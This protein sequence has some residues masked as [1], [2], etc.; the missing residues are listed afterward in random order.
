MR[1]DE[2]GGGR[3][4]PDGGLLQLLLGR[5]RS[6]WTRVRRFAAALF[7]RAR[8]ER[9]MTAEMAHHLELEIEDRVRRGMEPTEARR[10]AL[11]D[12]GGVERW[13]EEGRAARGVGGWDVL[14]QDLR[15]AWRA[16][17][18]SPGF[19]A[20]S[21]LTL[22]LGIGA[23]TAV[24]SVVDGLLL[25]PL[26]YHEPDR[27]VRLLDYRE[28][29]SG[30]GTIS[31]PNFYDWL[32][33]ST[34]FEAGALYDEYSPTLRLEGEAMKLEAAS[35]GAAYFDVLGVRPAAGRLFVAEDDEP[36]SR[37][38]VLSW[39]LWQELFGGS[40]DA[41]GRTLD[42][43][44]FPYTV[45]GVAQPME[46]PRLSYSSTTG[47]RLWRSTP[48]YFPT[49]GRGGRS[50]TAIAR[51]KPGVSVSEAQAELSAIY[52]RLA[53]EYPEANAGHIVRVA[54][55][56]DDLVGE[57]RPVL[58]M[59]LGA[60]GLVLLIA[61]ANVANLLL[62][63]AAGRSREIALRSALGASRGRIVRQLLVESLLLS[64]AGAVAGIGIAV[65]ATG[66]VLRLAAGHLPRVSG[67]GLDP[68]V[69]SFALAA[70]VFATLVF[71]LIPALQT[72]RPE[73]AE[74]LKEGGRGSAGS[75]R[76]GR[77]RTTVVAAEV[78]LAVVVMLGA[79]LLGRSLLR[80]HAVDPGVAADRTLVMRVDPPFDP[81][82]PNTAE[83][84]AA[85]MA[86]ND[87]LHERL[88]RVPGVEAVGITDLLPMSGNFNGNGFR[89][90]GRPE[91]EPGQLPSAE[92]RAIDPHYFGAMGIPVLEGR[93]V[94]PTDGPD[95][96][97]VIVV[98][99]A[100]A[101]RFFDGDAV[102]EAIR[103]F[104]PDAPPAEIV[105][106]VGNVTQFS[107]DEAPVP[108]LY[109]PHPQA[110]GWMRDEPWLVV[111]TAGDPAALVA[112]LRSAVHDV[113][114]R[115]PVYGIAPMADVVDRTLARPRFRA[116]LLL[117]FAALAFVLSAT[118][119]YGLVAYS[120]AR[121]LPELGVRMALGASRAGIRRLVVRQGLRPVLIGAVLGLA[122]GL[123][124]V[125]LLAGFLFG[126]P[127]TDP[128]TFVAVPGTLIAV[129]GLAAWLPAVRAART[130]P[131]GILRAE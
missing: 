69:L 101:D 89:I 129:A 113:D 116:V 22:A 72:A 85:V 62:F 18:G 58:W 61:C 51:L 44:G 105:G 59:L 27:I 79:G 11:R 76:Q 42:L 80:L 70:A 35:V 122:V 13:K 60:V 123:G 64:G 49:N 23:T 31:S 97:R 117:A 43:N 9:E 14:R 30:R 29:G 21:V 57:V 92:S 106:V 93:G 83:G 120:V 54:P 87:R 88:V 15:Y 36:G 104:D 102:G 55:L 121:R 20:V 25:E 46:N 75:R 26:G 77:L 38:V 125:R 17:S 65:A 8:L 12:F 128:V 52:A 39:G 109:V 10:T 34:A 108:T 111:R 67:V 53:E 66:G 68:G 118:G 71:G 45:V 86:L 95:E 110:P 63:R 19:A 2:A 119:V 90:V 91:P 96:R 50:F 78:A 94:E 24:F 112:S 16:L 3:R 37:R 82:D 48:S 32:E 131:A 130:E 99:Q 4:T 81:Y 73:G 7:G 100:F 84:S 114:P 127:P 33:Q 6:T 115:I 103:I 56:K 47:P 107:L 5:L 41:V 124:A 40:P 1:H 28:D 98:S 126:I 74:A